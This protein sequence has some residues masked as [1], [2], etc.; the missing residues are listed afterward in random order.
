MKVSV[1]GSRTFNDYDLLAS[2]LNDYIIQEIIS[3]GA[4][5]ADMLA[6]QYAKE[7]GIPTTI[8]LPDYARLGKAAPLKRNEDIIR[9]C[10]KVIAF[11]DGKSRGTQHA[12]N[13]ARKLGKAIIIIE[14]N[15]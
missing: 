13:F 3:G 15:L 6:E 8:F 4:K 5:G 14:Y 10:D 7:K 1:I 11:W 12:L 2:K 9:S